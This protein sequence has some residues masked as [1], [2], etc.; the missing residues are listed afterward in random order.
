[1]LNDEQLD[2]RKPFDV[3]SEYMHAKSFAKVSFYWCNKS[4]D[5]LDAINAH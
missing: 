1:M 5:G 4:T 3:P 2:E